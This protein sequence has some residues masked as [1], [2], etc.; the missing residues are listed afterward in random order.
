VAYRPPELLEAHH[1]LDDF[2]CEEPALTD[3]LKRY[4]RAAHADGSSRVYV[5][6]TEDPNDVIGYF[7]LSS[8][9]VA[10]EEATPRALKGQPQSRA[11]PAILLARLAR[12]DRHRRVGLGPSLLKDALLRCVDAAD[13]IG[14][15]VLLVHAKHERAKAFYLEY[16]FEDSPTDP[17]H[18]ILLMKDVRAIVK[19]L[20]G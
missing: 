6:T 16:G 10:P 12:D 18:L 19:K 8:A 9:S 13:T 3:W 1:R 5:A 2:Q 20:A 17:L 7:A 4:A 14:V 15:R 11:V